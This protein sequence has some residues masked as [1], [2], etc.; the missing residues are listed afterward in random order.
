MFSEPEGAS[1]SVPSKASEGLPKY[2]RKRV[3]ADN[4][5]VSNLLLDAWSLAIFNLW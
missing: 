1:C 2:A 4:D 3:V 5:E